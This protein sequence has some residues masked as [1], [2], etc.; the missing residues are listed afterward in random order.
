MEEVGLN[1]GPN[2][3]LQLAGSQIELGPPGAGGSQ[4]IELLRAAAVEMG[5]I[6]EAGPAAGA[7]GAE[8][9]NLLLCFLVLTYPC[10]KAHHLFHQDSLL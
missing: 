8:I 9:P 4:G 6:G 7:E 1:A 5:L 10:P 2:L 3:Q